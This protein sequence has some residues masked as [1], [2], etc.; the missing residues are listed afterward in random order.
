MNAK[1]VPIT[2]SD[3]IA[4]LRR[5]VLYGLAVDSVTPNAVFMC[6]QCGT[7]IGFTDATQRLDVRDVNC[8]ECGTFNTLQAA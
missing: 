3:D 2:T 4:S 5:K 6:L 7:I 1:R 8:P